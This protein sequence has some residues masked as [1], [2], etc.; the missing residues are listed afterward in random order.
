MCFGFLSFFFLIMRCWSA[1][2]E[3]HYSGGKG[4][5]LHKVRKKADFGGR[6][7][8]FQ[9]GQDQKTLFDKVSA[10]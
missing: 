2:I 10:I 8:R 6:C 7:L 3:V 5:R 1:S 4:W 9:K